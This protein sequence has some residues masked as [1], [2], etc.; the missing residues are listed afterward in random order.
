MKKDGSLSSKSKRRIPKYFAFVVPRSSCNVLFYLR[1][2]RNPGFSRK[3]SVKDNIM[4]TI[5][6]KR[7]RK[8]LTNFYRF[9]IR[10]SKMNRTLQMLSQCEFFKHNVRRFYLLSDLAS[11]QKKLEQDKKKIEFLKARRMFKPF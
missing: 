1:R 11:L 10:E 6:K 9:Q 4:K 3:R 2:G 7:R 8:E 5:K